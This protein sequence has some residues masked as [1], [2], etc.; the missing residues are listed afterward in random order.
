MRT[1]VLD[2]RERGRV[3]VLTIK[4]WHDGRHHRKKVANLLT[5]PYSESILGASGRTLLLF[6]I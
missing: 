1:H 4:E 6:L 5:S 3:V 2:H